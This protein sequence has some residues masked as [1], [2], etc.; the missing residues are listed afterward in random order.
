MSRR[1]KKNEKGIYPFCYY[2]FGDN[3]YSVAFINKK[4][5]HKRVGYTF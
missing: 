3:A 5:K 4:R 2:F 1:V